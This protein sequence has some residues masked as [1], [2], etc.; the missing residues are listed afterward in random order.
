MRGFQVY[1]VEGLP[2][3]SCGDDLAGLTVE[4]LEKLGLPLREGDIIVYSSKLVSKAEGRIVDIRGVEASRR[5]KV[6]AAGLGRPA[7]FIQLVL[8]ESVEVLG[9]WD[10]LLIVLDKRGMVC[11]NA[12]VDKSNVEGEYSYSLL[13]EDP[14]GSAEELLRRLREASGITRLGVVLADSA[15]RPFRKGMIHYALA[16]A[17]LRG[18]WDYRGSS[19][20]YGRTLRFKV[21]STADMLACAAGLVMGEASEK[22][23]AALIRGLGNLTTEDEECEKLTVD[24]WQDIYHGVFQPHHRRREAPSDGSPKPISPSPPKIPGERG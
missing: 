6:L 12:G 5:A 10:G 13:P 2:L 9:I 18:L 8:D 24:G 11:V 17:G 20:I 22:V 3:I 7:G 19:D 15:T 1:P 14:Y 23:G 4:A 16:C 21:S